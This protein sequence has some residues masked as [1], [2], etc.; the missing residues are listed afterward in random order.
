MKKFIAVFFLLILSPKIAYATDDFLV[1]GE[2]T[3]EVDGSATKVTQEI[4]ITNATTEVHATDFT[5]SL[6]GAE[7]SQARAFTEDGELEVEL[8]KG[9]VVKLKVL[10]DESI[11]GE[12]N[13]QNFTIEYLDASV[14]RVS[15]DV[16]EVSIPKL[17]TETF[18]TYLIRLKVPNSFGAHSYMSPPPDNELGTGGFTTYYF[19]KAVV[20][21]G[22]SA[23]FGKFQVFSFDLTYHLQNPLALPTEMEVALPPDTS[24]QKIFYQSVS[25]K[26]DNI[27]VDPDGNWLAVYNLH[28]RER[29]D[30]RAIGVV[31]VFASPWRQFASNSPLEGSVYW[32]VEDPKVVEIAN[33][34]A[35]PKEIY[36]YVVNTLNYNYEKVTTGSKRLGALSALENPAESICTEF[37]DLFIALA[38]AKGIPAR[39]VNGYAY[40]DNTSL[41]PLALVA[42]VLHAWP[43][44]WDSERDLWVPVDPTWGKTTGGVDYFTKLDMRHINF[45]MHGVS[46]ELPIPP[47]SYKLGANPQKD[48][49]V[50]LGE[51]PQNTSSIPAISISQRGSLPFQGL[52]LVA[53]IE[54]PGP[55]AL[56]DQK[57]ELFFDS[58][59][60]YES[61]LTTLLPYEKR[62]LEF[63]V[64]Y[65]FLGSSMPETAELYVG[66]ARE[67]FA[68]NKNPA[69]ARDVIA[70]SLTVVFCVAGVVIYIRRRK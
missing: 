59:K 26:P 62:I 38:R 65:G 25:P 41:R 3:Y 46:P 44:Y 58:A 36:D 54:N 23:A 67:E 66:N 24:F 17:A 57:V 18:D 2:A 28:A 8:T 27:L 29:L 22:V 51:L 11:V 47:G 43:E 68:T 9:D 13:S 14:V 4:S 31:Q 6:K 45:V 52:V 32:Q 64:P 16:T 21:L 56:Y 12:G 33:G 34:L 1:S 37:T 5:L 30:V 15:G 7:V 69:L 10:F 49:F 61:N 40:T 55:A 70:I 53:E 50:A 48:V 19:D 42:D 60:K 35:S 63:T 20:T 39:E